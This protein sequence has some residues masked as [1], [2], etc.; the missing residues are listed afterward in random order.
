MACVESSGA[1]DNLYT[2]V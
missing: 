1:N 2:V